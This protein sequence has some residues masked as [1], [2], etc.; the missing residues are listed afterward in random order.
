MKT[1]A[2]LTITLMIVIA[3]PLA[4]ADIITL[5]GTLMGSSYI[6]GASPVSGEFRIPPLGSDFVTP[7]DIVSATVTFSFSDDSEWVLAGTS[8]PQYTGLH[9]FSGNYY[10]G[11]PVYYR[12][13]NVY[14][15]YQND[16]DSANVQVGGQNLSANS[17]SV[18]YSSTMYGYSGYSGPYYYY[19]WQGYRHY[20]L[21][22]DFYRNLNTYSGY[23]GSFGTTSALEADTLADLASDGVL[24]WTIGGGGD[25]YFTGATLTMDIQPNP[26]PDPVPEPSSML[27]LGTGLGGILL[28]ARK[29]QK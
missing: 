23:T 16:G 22:Q 21:D 10:L 5:P 4:R 1:L 17:N 7:Y 11:Y 8:G 12:E 15:Q 24:Q 6:S 3:A 29:W 27:L 26:V 25:F 28:R 13:F 9:Y 18:S 19:D 20:Y 2:M 14:N